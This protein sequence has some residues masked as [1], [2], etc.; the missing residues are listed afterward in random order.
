MIT[1]ENLIEAAEKL[2]G[3]K[4]EIDFVED[5]EDSY[6][7]IQSIDPD[8]CDEYITVAKLYN[9]NN[10]NWFFLRT[11]IDLD[12]GDYSG[13]ELEYDNETPKE[14]LKLIVDMVKDDINEH[15]SY[16]ET[17]IEDLE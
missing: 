1:K 15:I 12:A 14:F 2:Y 9:Y 5:G 6:F 13:L 10:D 16:Y 7:D 8:E 17:I 3:D 11:I 4:M